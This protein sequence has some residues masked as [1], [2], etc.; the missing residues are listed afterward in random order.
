MSIRRARDQRLLE[1]I[2]GARRVLIPLHLSPDGDSVGSALAMASA[3]RHLG[4]RATVVSSDPPPRL[5]RYLHGWEEIRRPDDVGPDHDMLMLLDCSSV[6][7]VGRVRDVFACTGLPLTVTIDH[8]RTGVLVGDFQWI[9]PEAA[10]TAEMVFDWMVRSGVP[11]DSRVAA[12][13]YTG[14]ATDTGFFAFS[15]TTASTLARASALVH[16]GVKPHEVHCW[17][18]EDRPLRT[19]RILGRAL[20]KMQAEMGGRLVWTLVTADDLRDKGAVAGD[21]EG[22]INHLRA[23]SGTEMCVIF[24]EAE[25]GHVKMSFR[26]RER[27]DVSAVA[28]RF[29]GGGHA[30]AAGAKIKGDTEKVVNEVL[31]ASRKVLADLGEAGDSCAE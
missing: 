4:S 11:I 18:N 30:R 29:G 25:T 27:V 15:N 13:L 7:R 20:D 6:S 23:V 21:T 31:T 19:V 28:S 26:S 16:R 3:C 2:R 1:L 22:V 8:H 17:V 10:A 14:I 24:V 12:A 9:D 5:Y